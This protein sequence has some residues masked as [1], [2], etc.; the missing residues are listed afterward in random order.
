MRDNVNHTCRLE[1]NAPLDG[2]KDV[3]F[4]ALAFDLQ[5]PPVENIPVPKISLSLDNVSIEIMRYLDQAIETQDMIGNPIPVI[6]GRHLIYPDFASQPYYRYIDN[7]QYVY[8]LHCIG[9]GEYDVEQI[10]IEDTPIS[11]FEEITCQIIR[12]NEK[13]TLFDEDVITSAEVAGQELLKNEY[14]GPFVLN[15][16]ETLISK[17]EVDVA[18]QRGCYYANDSGGLSSKTIQWKIEVRS[19]DDNDTPLGEW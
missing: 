18:F 15:P 2:G 8:Q 3:E 9:Q 11:S 4:I 7:E 13:N 6:Y 16:A 14:C 19:I 17:I 10:R 12:P 1:D 5:L